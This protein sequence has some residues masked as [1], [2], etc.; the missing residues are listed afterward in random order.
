MVNR[1]SR[2]ATVETHEFNVVVIGAGP[3][4]ENLAEHARAGGLAT[5][6]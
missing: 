2:D 3:P 4:G 6:A 1:L 5:A